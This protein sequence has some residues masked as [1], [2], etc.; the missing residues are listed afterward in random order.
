MHCSKNFKR[1][2]FHVKN[3]NYFLKIIESS[4][5]LLQTFSCRLE[6]CIG[7]SRG[8]KPLKWG[9]WPA[10]LFSAGLHPMQTHSLLLE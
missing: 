1:I 5:V 2:T 3:M 4:R 10:G 8:T 6:V 9:D 7:K